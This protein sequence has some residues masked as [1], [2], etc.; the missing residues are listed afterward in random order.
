L[1]GTPSLNPGGR[2][3]SIAHLVREATQDGTLLINKLVR[4]WN[5]DEPG[6]GSREVMLAGQILLDRGHGRATE[7]QVQVQLDGEAALGAM[8]LATDALEVMARTFRL[9]LP[10]D[11]PALQI[12]EGQAVDSAIPVDSG[13]PNDA[14]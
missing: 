4:I 8:D 3:K 2:P 10:S 14:E 11:P 5:G 7:T 6:F 9:D 13:D 1:P 12:V